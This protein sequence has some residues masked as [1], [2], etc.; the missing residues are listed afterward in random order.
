MK[1]KISSILFLLF[2]STLCMTYF[3]TNVVIFQLVV[4]AVILLC[5]FY[6]PKVPIRC[7]RNLYALL[8][9]FTLLYLIRAFVVLC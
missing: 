6:A 8:C 2:T 5:Y 3:T 9:A 4:Y 1:K 7:N